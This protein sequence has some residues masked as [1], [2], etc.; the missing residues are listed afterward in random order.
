MS[1]RLSPSLRAFS[2]CVFA[3]GC[4]DDT[5]PVTPDA[6]LDAGRRD[7]GPGDAGAPACVGSPTDC[8]TLTLETCGTVMGCRQTQCLGFPVDCSRR[9]MAHCMESTG[10]RW[11]DGLCSGT[12]VACAES[13]DPAACNANTGCTYGL[14]L[15]C[16]G[17]PVR[18]ETFTEA[19]CT[20]QPGCMIYVPPFDAGP[21]PD[22]GPPMTDAGCGTFDA[23]PPGVADV[24]V[25][26]VL[27]PPPF[28]P[29]AGITV[30]VESECFGSMEETTDA[31]G[32]VGFTLAR[33][34][35]P[36]SLTAATAGYAA[37]S[38]LDVA[39][40][41]MLMGDIRLDPVNVPVEMPYTVSGTLAGAVG[42]GNSVQIDAY[43]FETIAMAGAM[44]SANFYASSA[45]I[46]QPLTFTA[47]EQDRMGIAV[48]MATAEVPRV[49][50]PLSGI[51]LAMPAP[52]IPPVVTNVVARLPDMGMVT[53]TDAMPVSASAQ[54]LSTLDPAQF[55]FTGTAQIR[56]AGGAATMTLQHYPSVLATNHAFGT[57][58]STT[59][60]LNF[61]RSDLSDTSEIV[62]GPGTMVL[63]GSTLGDLQVIQTGAAGHDAI[64]IHIDETGDH[65]P[66][67]RVFA[68]TLPQYTRV[69]HLP[70]DV[71][72]TDIGIMADTFVPVLPLFIKAESGALW[73]TFSNNRG[74]LG[75]EYTLAPGYTFIGASGR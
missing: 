62:V 11:A 46:R 49:E 12:P 39:N 26:V 29:A 7:A 47:I 60:R 21:P 58:D 48:N 71:T 9:D 63:S 31:D 67:W 73:S 70:S 3:L 52:R 8:S 24:S 40:V 53:S 25:R 33:E 36:W 50:M 72:L 13:A 6:G 74:V 20:S 5:T 55:I 28:M 30:R 64:V 34:M 1:L 32:R 27:G 14:M 41:D 15:V 66:R 23:G 18:C 2:V 45:S 65:G 69:P 59:A 57:V 16:R 4:G 75:Y 17:A 19:M 38:I 22:S 10:C 54:R 37:V 35:G 61:Y 68:P 56:V 44:W 42:V 51:S 43:N